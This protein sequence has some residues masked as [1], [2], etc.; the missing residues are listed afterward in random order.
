MHTTR[1]VFTSTTTSDLKFKD[2]DITYDGGMA[3]VWQGQAKAFALPIASIVAVER[4]PD[5]APAPEP[6]PSGDAS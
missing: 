2:A 5:P 6:E 3:V 4:I 1:I